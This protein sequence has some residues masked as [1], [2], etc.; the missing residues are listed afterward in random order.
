M[1]E[2][3]SSWDGLLDLGWL[4]FLSLLLAYFWLQRHTMLKAQHWQKT[5]GHI[6]RFE[7]ITHGHR[8]WPK[9]EYIYQVH[10]QEFIG[11]HLF[12][13]MTYINPNSRYAR[14]FAYQV[15]NAYKNNEDLAVFYNPEKPAQAVLN[16]S[17]PRKLNLIIVL[18]SAL[19]ALHLLG[20]YRQV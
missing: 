2:L 19:I 1:K 4:L 8:V 20:I 18:I 12:V 11:E 3:F 17:M 13:D 10:D 14:K 5:R 7:W 9:I 6:S 15:A 16:V